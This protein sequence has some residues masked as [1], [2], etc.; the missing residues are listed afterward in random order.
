MKNHLN[1]DRYKSLDFDERDEIHCEGS[2]GC[3]EYGRSTFLEVLRFTSIEEDGHIVFPDND[4][5]CFFLFIDHN[6]AG[7]ELPFQTLGEVAKNYDWTKKEL[8]W[9]YDSYK[10]D[11][12]DGLHMKAI[13]FNLM[14]NLQWE[15]LQA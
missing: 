2:I 15:H 6:D 7:E 5:D 1:L 9:Q 8:Q 14:K 3:I 10:F 13:L 4:T 12:I 11:G